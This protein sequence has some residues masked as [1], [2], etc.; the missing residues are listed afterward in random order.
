MC[1]LLLGAVINMVLD[2]I[3]IYTL[4]MGV[5]GAAIATAISQIVSTIVYLFYVLRKKSAFS[6]SLKEFVPKKE[7]MVEILKIGVPTLTFQ[8]L[9]G[10]SIALINRVANGY[11]D[12]VI[13]GMGAVTRVTSMGTLVV[14][15]FLK[16]FQPIAGLLMALFSTQI[17]SQ[18]ANGNE[19]MMLLGKNHLWQTASHS[20][21]LV[22]IPYILHCSLHLEKA[23]PAL[24]LELADKVFALFLLFC[25]FRHF[26]E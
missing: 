7:I 14:F 23:L 12:A 16:G 1:A 17:I 19:A 26:G 4:N 5:A 18:F 11:S 20:S 8:L 2:P 6:F 13:A 24:F 21:L 25:F 9:T 10:L 3:F 22:F 15:G